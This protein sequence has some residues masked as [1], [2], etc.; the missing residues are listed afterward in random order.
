M[1]SFAFILF[2]SITLSNIGKAQNANASISFSNTRKEV[3]GIGDTLQIRVQV[4]IPPEICSDGMQR[5]KIYV[6]GLELYK[7][8]EWQQKTGQVWRKQMAFIVTSNKKGQGK[9]TVIRKADKGDFFLQEKINIA[10]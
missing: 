2:F 1:K 8:G 10:K 5:T 9:I 7:Q 3:Y 4:R 6:S